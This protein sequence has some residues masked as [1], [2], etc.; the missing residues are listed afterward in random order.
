MGKDSTSSHLIIA[1]R[2]RRRV[3][4]TLIPV[5][6]P[7][8]NNDTEALRVRQE[9]FRLR[10]LGLDCRRRRRGTGSRRWSVDSSDS[11]RE[12]RCFVD[13]RRR[14]RRRGIIG[15]RRRQ[16]RQGRRRRLVYSHQG[17][18]EQQLFAPGCC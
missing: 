15:A 9:L 3:F 1:G 10:Q 16:L 13:D 12:K 8:K 5:F 11:R 7:P 2:R 4:L 14:C 18:R 17:R 6:S